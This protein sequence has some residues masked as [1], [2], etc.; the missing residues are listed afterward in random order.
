MIPIGTILPNASWNKDVAAL[1]ERL[2]FSFSKSREVERK[3]CRSCRQQRENQQQ[4]REANGQN[5]HSKQS[6]QQ[7]K[8]S[9]VKP[10]KSDLN[11][12]K[13]N[14][15][16]V[17]YDYI[18]VISLQE[19]KQKHQEKIDGALV[20][21][22][23][24]RKNSR[25]GIWLQSDGINP[26]GVEDRSPTDG[27]EPPPQQEV[28]RYRPPEIIHITDLMLKVGM[29]R[30]FYSGSCC[31]GCGSKKVRIICSRCRNAKYC[32]VKCLKRDRNFKH[33]WHCNE[34]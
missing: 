26:S 31:H 11:Q 24:Q 23:K 25:I 1:T 22:T 9:V 14:C 13:N 10:R 6:L 12:S 3:S 30:Y 16:T 28:K 34:W 27:A 32:S 5:R 29:L 33:L 4:R 18:T 21:L 15:G 20:D 2:F 8:K 7:L 19:K 17:G